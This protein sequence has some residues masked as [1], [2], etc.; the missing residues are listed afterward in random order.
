MPGKRESL[1]AMTRKQYI[2]AFKAKIAVEALREAK[3]LTQIASDYE[4]SPSLEREGLS[5]SRHTIRRYRQEM[6]LATL[7]PKP[8]T[9]VPGG[10]E[11]VI[12]P[13]LLRHLPI[14]R[15]DQVWGV[16]YPRSR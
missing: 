13:Y 1:V 7:Y 3:P 8:K 16:G 12:Y 2:G 11:C 6:G 15:P 10:P 5:V 14:E 4:L 9:S